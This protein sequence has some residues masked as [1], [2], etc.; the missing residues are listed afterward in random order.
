[1]PF[2]I[3]QL[4]PLLRRLPVLAWLTIDMPLA[5]T[6]HIFSSGGANLSLSSNQTFI[7]SGQLVVW[8]IQLI[9]QLSV[10][11]FTEDQF[12]LVQ[13]HLGQILVTLATLYEV[14][15]HHLAD[16]TII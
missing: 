8:S 1:M 12:G 5:E 14:N 10:A 4:I 7:A 6:A 16:L 11:S 15:M 13:M 9:S 2:F 3:P